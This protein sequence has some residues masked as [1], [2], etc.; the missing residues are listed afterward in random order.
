MEV[1]ILVL[2]KTESQI[3]LFLFWPS[4]DVEG[5]EEER[6]MAP[7]YDV[8][9]P[10]AFGGKETRAYKTKEGEAEGFTIEET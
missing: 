10:S 6:Q 1:S 5:E 2:T 9:P 3:L 8:S 7:V 4:E